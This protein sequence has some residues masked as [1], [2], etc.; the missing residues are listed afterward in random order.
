MSTVHASP[1]G[2]TRA[3]PH[4]K[5]TIL[6]SATVC[7]ACNR[8]LHFDAVRTGRRPPPILCPLHIEG[9]IRHPAGGEPWEYSI[10]LEVHDGRGGVI[11]RNTVGVGA[12]RP[13]EARTFTVRVEVFAPEKSA[14]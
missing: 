10:V 2:E 6:M 4:C 12:L 5:A 14:V 3:C 8:Y 13:G 7:P 9:T 11:S 1:S